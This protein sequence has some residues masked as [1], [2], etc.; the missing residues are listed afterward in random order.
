MKPMNNVMQDFRKKTIEET[1]N[2]LKTDLGLGLSQSEVDR[3]LKQYGYNEVPEKKVHPIVLF[4]RKFW[5][6]TAWMLEAIIVLAL[7]LGKYIDLYTVTALLVLNSILGFIQEQRASKAVELLKSKLQ[8]NAR[9]LRDGVWRLVPSRE[10]V[11]GDV[12]RVRAGDFVPADIKIAIGEVWV[13]QSALTGESME[14]EKRLGDILYSGSIIRR[15][16]STGIV[17]LTGVKT[18]FGRTAQLVQVARPKLHMEEVVSRVLKWLLVIVGVMLCIAAIFSVIRGIDLLEI[19]PLMLVLMLGAVPVA[20]PAMFTVSMAVGSMELAGKNVLVTRLSASDDAASMDVLCVDKTGTITMNRLSMVDVKP[21]GNHDEDEVILCGALASQEANQDPIDLAFI[22]MARRRK[23]PLDDFTQKSF[24]PFDPK[25]RRTEALIQVNGSEFRVVKGAVNTVAEICRLDDNRLKEVMEKV[26]KFTQRGYR[27]IAVAKSIGDESFELVGLAALYDA[28]RPDAKN[29]IEELKS[30]GVAV[31]MMTGDALPI[32]KEIAK[33]IG[34]GNNVIKASEL[35]ELMKG[36][37]SRAG[38]IAEGSSGFAEVYPEDKYVIVKS[39]QERAH[40][41]GMTGDGVNDAPALRQAEVG[42]AVANATDVA[43]G[44]ASVVLTSE[45]L[46]SMLTLVEIGRSIF[47]RINTWI[48]NKITRTILKTVFV[49]SA[50][51]LTG[52]YVISSSAMLLMLFMTDFVKISLST[53]NVRW[54]KNPCKWNITGLMK[55]AI[56]LGSLMVLE[57]FGLL[58]IGIRFFNILSDEQTLH[59]F[60]FQTLLLFALFSILV[61]RERGHFWHSKPGKALLI[62][63]VLDLTVAILIALFGMPSLKPLPPILMLT[64]L[65]YSAIFSLIINDFIKYILMKKQYLKW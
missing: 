63:V 25:T 38:E 24:I 40:I 22:D 44:A 13:D 41:V 17:V 51:L 31:K 4:V 34:L 60:S 23:L 42:I 47:E 7:V 53:D 6:L 43:K 56:I 20:L 58:F 18:Y 2:L 9:V 15:G 61:A 35:K 57:A 32:A 11:P 14:V 5:G 1:V 3:R 54:S 36:D 46:T 19:L 30:L 28:P 49:V 45:G 21:L 39:L 8:I 12:V 65:G 33:E 64:V 37:Q 55:V 50:F 26:D 62:A 52:K 10:L 48:L 59:M 16:E 29:L 27:T